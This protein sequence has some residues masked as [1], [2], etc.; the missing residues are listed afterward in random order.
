MR[1][2]FEIITPIRVQNSILIGEVFQIEVSDG[3]VHSFGSYQKIY[4]Y[5]ARVLTGARVF[6]SLYVFRVQNE[7]SIVSVQNSILIGEVFQIEV[8]DGPVHSLGS[9][10]KVNLYLARL[11]TG[12]MRSLQVFTIRPDHSNG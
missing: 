6:R 7:H 4:L 2:E 11:F 3:L 5:I 9:S 12:A 1:L 10:Q 8:S